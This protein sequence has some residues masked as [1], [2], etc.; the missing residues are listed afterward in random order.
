[1]IDFHGI[2][3]RISEAFGGLTRSEI[4]NRLGVN[5]Q[6]FSNWMNG[7]NEFPVSQLAKVTE[8]T[9]H[10]IHWIL[11]G[12]EPKMLNVDLNIDSILREMVRQIVHEEISARELMALQLDGVDAFD[13]EE[14]IR[15]LKEPRAVL[16]EWYLHEKSKVPAGV[17]TVIIS[18]WESL[19]YLAKMKRLRVARRDLD[20]SQKH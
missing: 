5:Y 7:R 11:T 6:T 2:E 12:V 14:S 16:R 3:M 10:S 4:A 17:D 1:M 18:G 8:L 9:N 19:S 15:R 13:L 20:T